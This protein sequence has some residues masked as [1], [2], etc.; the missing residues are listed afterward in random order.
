MAKE[1]LGSPLHLGI[2]QSDPA[3]LGL[4]RPKLTAR[5]F[6]SILLAYEADV[7]DLAQAATMIM[8]RYTVSVNLEGSLT[9]FLCT[10]L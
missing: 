7:A 10:S 5:V 8:T 6:E 9:S 1:I 2:G 3:A 4:F